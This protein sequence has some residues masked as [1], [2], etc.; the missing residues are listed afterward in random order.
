MLEREDEMSKDHRKS[1]RINFEAPIKLF[2]SDGK[3]LECH[4]FNFSDNGLYAN[5]EPAITSMLG[6]G[7]IVRVQFQGLNYTP[8]I[9]TSEV[10]RIDGK[11]A[12]F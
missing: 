6:L 4:S 1:Q 7:T 9:V 8:P 5:L 3:V 12:G 11:C 2:F 10:V